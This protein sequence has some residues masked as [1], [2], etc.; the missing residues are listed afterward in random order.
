MVKI[1][2][3]VPYKVTLEE[4]NGR[5]KKNSQKLSVGAFHEFEI[6]E[7]SME[8]CTVVAQWDRRWPG[9]EQIVRSDVILAYDD[10][11]I[12]HEENPGLGCLISYGGEFYSSARFAIEDNVQLLNIDNIEKVIMRADSI[13]PADAPRRNL[14]IRVVGDVG[15]SDEESFTVY[16]SGN[17]FSTD[18]KKMV[19]TTENDNVAKIKRSLARFVVIDGMVCFKTWEPQLFISDRGGRSYAGFDM[20]DPYRDQ[21]ILDVVE[22]SFGLVESDFA[23]RVLEE[24]FPGVEAYFANVKVFETERLWQGPDNV[25]FYKAARYVQERLTKLTHEMSPVTFTHWYDMKEILKKD[26]ED[27]SEHEVEKL[28]ELASALTASIMSD[29]DVKDSELCT[30]MLR[31]ATILQERWLFRPMALD[32]DNTSRLSV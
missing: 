6:E 20:F 23:E 26:A 16:P 19:S 30:R 14:N 5:Y 22:Y 3:A 13:T 18:K 17:D 31:Y 9:Q 32:L 10:W 27:V 21:G 24:H 4:K 2:L 11:R 1:T 7:L 29:D 8:D 28:V 25:E 15:F 12:K